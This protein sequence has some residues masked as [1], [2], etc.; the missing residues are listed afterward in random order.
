MEHT[1]ESIA[2]FRRLVEAATGRSTFA[3][4][5]HG[6]GVSCN[7]RVTCPFSVLNAGKPYD[8]EANKP[9]APAKQPIGYF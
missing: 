6:P 7:E 4:C 2:A 9:V 3:V 5:C 8:H 1:T